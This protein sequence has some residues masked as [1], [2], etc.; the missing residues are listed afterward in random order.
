[1]RNLADLRVAASMPGAA[2]FVS[3]VTVLG[4]AQE[5]P[6]HQQGLRTVYEVNEDAIFFNDGKM[7][8]LGCAA[9]LVFD[10]SP[11][12]F[13]AEIGPAKVQYEIIQGAC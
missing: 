8:P 6:A 11:D 9:N 10:G 2:L 5:V 1:M 3:S 4:H 13:W 7:M 12:R